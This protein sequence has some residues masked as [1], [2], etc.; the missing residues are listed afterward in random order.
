MILTRIFSIINCYQLSDVALSIVINWVHSL[1]K[2][3][4][5]HR[6]FLILLRQIICF[7]SATII[8]SLLGLDNANFTA[9]WS[10]TF[11]FPHFL[12]LS[13]NYC[14]NRECYGWNNIEVR[15]E[16]IKL[17]LPWRTRNGWKKVDL[18]RVCSGDLIE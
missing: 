15:S 11:Q 14:Q 7:Q 1:W 9:I 13:G 4:M 2:W 12:Q 10:V 16:G 8:V 17:H 18:V 3:P 6:I 5:L